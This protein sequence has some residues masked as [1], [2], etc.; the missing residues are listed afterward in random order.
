MMDGYF[1]YPYRGYKS[2]NEKIDDEFDMF[3]LDMTMTSRHHIFSRSYEIEMKKR[4]RANLKRIIKKM[5]E[6]E[7][8]QLYFSQDNILEA[9]YIFLS[10]MKENPLKNMKAGI[11]LWLRQVLNT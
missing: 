9:A 11:D 8:K 5:N 1:L 6:D 2:L 3:F 7:I 10:S 4:I